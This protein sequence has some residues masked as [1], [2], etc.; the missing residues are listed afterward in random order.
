M[1]VELAE[2]TLGIVGLGRIG[3]EV[4]VRMQAF[5]M[6]VSQEWSDCLVSWLVFFSVVQ[7]VGYDPL[8]PAEEAKKFGVKF[9]EL[10]EMWPM[11]D[12]VTVHTPL[13]K[14]TRGTEGSQLSER[15]GTNKISTCSISE[16]VWISKQ[17]IKFYCIA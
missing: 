11:V 3:R 13:I 14:A 16:L 1:G 12:F 8:V 15:L 4:A 2:K 5:G 6:K 9:V 10:E 17:A 7:T